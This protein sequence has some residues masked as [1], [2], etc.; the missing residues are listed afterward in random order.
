MIV[1]GTN[2]LVSITGLSL[3]DRYGALTCCLCSAV[4]VADIIHPVCGFSHLSQTLTHFSFHIWCAWVQSQDDRKWLTVQIRPD[5]EVVN[6][7][8]SIITA[9]LLIQNSA[10]L[11]AAVH[12]G[13][14]FAGYRGHSGW[15]FHPCFTEDRFLSERLLN[16][17]KGLERGFFSPSVILVRATCI[18]FPPFFNLLP[19]NQRWINQSTCLTRRSPAARRIADIWEMCVSQPSVLRFTEKLHPQRKILPV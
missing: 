15:E 17:F 7:F 9:E 6:Y 4:G 2:D 10:F 19:T 13:P 8:A 12:F 1:L 3:T 16:K 14:L 18:T 5:C 11:V